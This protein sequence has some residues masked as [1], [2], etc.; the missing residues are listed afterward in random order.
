MLPPFISPL[1]LGAP[2]LQYDLEIHAQFNSDSIHWSPKSMPSWGMPPFTLNGPLN[3]WSP[4]RYAI[5]RT[6]DLV[7]FPFHGTLSVDAV[8]QLGVALWGLR[9]AGCLS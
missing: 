1:E 6:M 9:N 5:P 7:F 3:L 2:F 8:L 4:E